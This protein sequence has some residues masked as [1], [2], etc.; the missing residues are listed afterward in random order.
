[1]SLHTVT[2]KVS[3]AALVFGLGLVF[4]GP[5]TTTSTAQAATLKECNCSA[6]KGDEFCECRMNHRLGRRGHTTKFRVECNHWTTE[7]EPDTLRVRNQDKNTT[8]TLAFIDHGYG[9]ISCTNW[10][11][12]KRDDVYVWA[13]CRWW[14]GCTHDLNESVTCGSDARK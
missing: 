5:M 13:K 11:W 14:D 2:C 12:S 1:M 10:A 8:C 4:A 7:T 9:S 3:A 6:S